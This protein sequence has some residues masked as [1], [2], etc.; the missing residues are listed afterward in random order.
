MLCPAQ[1]PYNSY[2]RVSIKKGVG[3][4]SRS[5]DTVYTLWCQFFFYNRYPSNMSATPGQQRTTDTL[6]STCKMGEDG[7]GYW[8]NGLL[9]CVQSN[10]NS[11]TIESHL[12]SIH[13]VD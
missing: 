8:D 5:V 9:D 6:S 11:M 13:V 3:N 10:E 12:N 4:F 1:Q 2:G 7:L